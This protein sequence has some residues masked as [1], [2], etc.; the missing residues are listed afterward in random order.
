MP[1]T[2]HQPNNSPRTSRA[3]RFLAG[4]ILGLG[5]TACGGGSSAESTPGGGQGITDGTFYFTDTNSGGSATEVRLVSTRFGRLVQLF[6]LDESGLR[7]PMGDDF[8]IPQSLASDE[9][10]Y[11]IGINAITGQEN[12]TVLRDVSTREGLEEF[13][14]LLQ[15]AGEGLDLIQVQ[16]LNT[17]G[18]FSMLPRNSAVV[19]T[20][21]DLID[22]NTINRNSIQIATGLPPAFPFEARI[23]PSAFLSSQPT[24]PVCSQ[25]LNHPGTSE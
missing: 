21:D 2:T 19:L 24:R 25:F 10:D 13:V 23:F 17:S 11:E 5:A 20:F 7:V 4:L 6:G 15:A 18:V 8:V 1:M 3:P 9:V 12:L 16:D 22:P 14:A